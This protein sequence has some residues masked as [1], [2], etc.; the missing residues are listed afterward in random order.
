MNTNIS[1][2]IRDFITSFWSKSAPKTSSSSNVATAPPKQK[3][4]SSKNQPT[5]SVSII[6]KG[7]KIV[8]NVQ[9]DN[10]VRFEG[11]LE[12]DIICDNAVIIGEQSKITG[13]INAKDLTIAG[14]YHGD[15]NVSQIIKLKKTAVINGNIV[16]PKM[17][18]EYGSSINGKCKIGS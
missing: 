8:G 6:G 11:T 9:V 15:I 10:D 18:A 14:T 4:A 2:T 1:L 13:N 17:M 7:C 3:K 16:A 12:G 5:K